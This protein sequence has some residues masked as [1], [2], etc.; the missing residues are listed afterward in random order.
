[1]YL[2][3][4]FSIETWLERVGIAGLKL[5]LSLGRST[6]SGCWTLLQKQER[7]RIGGGSP[8]AAPMPKSVF[9]V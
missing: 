9:S 1:M 5:E 4:P 6:G 8:V 2:M 7:K 3:M